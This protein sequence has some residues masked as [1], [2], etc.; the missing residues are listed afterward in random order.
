MT[1]GAGTARMVLSALTRTDSVGQQANRQRHFS[2][3]SV[4]ACEEER[5]AG[6]GSL[7]LIN[8]MAEEL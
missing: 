2:Y 7:S 5:L 6:G 8:H 4:Y 3:D 1:D